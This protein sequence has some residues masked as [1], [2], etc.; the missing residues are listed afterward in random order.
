MPGETPIIVNLP[1]ISVVAPD[2]VPLITTLT[3][4]RGS[5]VSNSVTLPLIFPTSP[6][7]ITIE[8]TEQI[9]MLYRITGKDF[10]SRDIIYILL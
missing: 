10:F 8:S 3:P 2:V 9:R 5:P 7:K 6:A 4:I 1:S